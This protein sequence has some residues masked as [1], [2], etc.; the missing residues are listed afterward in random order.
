MS[1]GE[2]NPEYASSVPVVQPPHPSL[3]EKGANLASSMKGWAASGFSLAT[4]EQLESR[5][6]ICKGCEF[7]NESGFAGTGSCKKC[8]CSTQ[9]KL[10]MATSKCPDGKW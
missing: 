10:R 7:W 1:K 5:M 4:P 8:G 6:A 2:N 3:L 9:A